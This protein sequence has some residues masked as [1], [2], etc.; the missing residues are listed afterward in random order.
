VAI[1][2]S[3]LQEYLTAIA[4]KANLDVANSRH[5]VFWNGSYQAFI[6]GIVPNKH[7]NGQVVPII[8]PENKSNSGFNQILRGSWCG[9][10]QM[11]KTGPFVT[12]PDYFVILADG[13]RVDGN[14]IVCPG[15]RRFF[16]AMEIV[17]QGSSDASDRRQGSTVS[18][19]TMLT[20]A[21]ASVG[22]SPCW[23]P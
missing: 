7:C 17:D 20:N 11:P 15:S 2:F 23:L 19:R 10:P 9:M 6:T 4:A 21:P 14:T 8:D 3:R 22:A 18:N 12:D 13:T 16:K 1:T 5:G